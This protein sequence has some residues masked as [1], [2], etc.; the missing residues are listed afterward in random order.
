[1]KFFFFKKK[2]E[3]K[4]D[5]TKLSNTVTGVILP[6]H[7]QL[8]GK[9][10]TGTIENTDSNTYLSVNACSTTGSEVV[11]QAL[12]T[13]DI[14]NLNHYL[15]FYVT[16]SKPN[17]SHSLRY[18]GLWN[19]ENSKLPKC[20]TRLGEFEKHKGIYISGCACSAAF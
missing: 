2:G 10:K 18:Y 19:W 7:W 6:G 3:W 8:P 16:C 15:K 12:R 20:A 4:L 11:E 1:M 14:I 9:G 5:N 17:C 13:K